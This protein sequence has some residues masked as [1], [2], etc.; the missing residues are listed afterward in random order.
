MLSFST[1]FRTSGGVCQTGGP[2]NTVLKKMNP[3]Y[4]ATSRS[5]FR[6]ANQSL[7]TSS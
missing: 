2:G 1:S 5:L 4:P 7:G 3:M 6:K